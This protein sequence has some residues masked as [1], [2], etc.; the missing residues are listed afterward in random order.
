MDL[1]IFPHLKESGERGL[2]YEELATKTKCDTDLLQRLMRHLVATNLLLYINGRLYGTALSNSLAEKKFQ[3]TM[4]WVH[5]VS[6][7]AF[8]ELPY[9]FRSKGYTQPTDVA[10]GPFQH[11]HK[12]TVSLYDWRDANPQYD[13]PFASL[14]SSFRA[15]KAD[16]FINGFY[17]VQDRLT[18]GFDTEI[19]DV[20]L[21]DVGGHRGDDLKRFASYHPTHPGRLVLQD[22]D[23]IV[24]SLIEGSEEVPFHVQAQDFFKPQAV[25]GARAYFLH[26]IL[27]NWNEED[28]IKILVQLKSAMKSGYSRVLISDIAVSDEHPTPGSTTMDLLMMTQCSSLERTEAQWK[29]LIERAGLKLC[30][31]Y[32]HPEAPESLIEAELV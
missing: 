32:N 25:K 29:N 17:P 15:D 9:Y 3:D 13:A 20:L 14:M 27:H 22:L 7:P 31:I 24:A 10:D 28:S 26:S 12:I 6:R 5:D 23:V 19:S 8:N 30:H 16:W 4:W 2:T 18:K 11:A 1:K 21:V